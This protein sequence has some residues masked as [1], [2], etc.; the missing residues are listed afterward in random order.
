MKNIK[1]TDNTSLS[2]QR[3]GKDLLK[4]L[5]IASQTPISENLQGIAVI[6][7]DISSSMAGNKIEQAK[8]GAIDFAE[9]SKKMGL[10]FGLVTFGS[11][12]KKIISHE[13]NIERLKAIINKI[14]VSGSTNMS[15]AIEMSIELCQHEHGKK[16]FCIVTDGMPDDPQKTIELAR[17]AKSCGIHILTIGTDDA[18]NNFLSQLA[19]KKDY[20]TIIDSKNLRNSLSSVVKMLPGLDG[21]NTKI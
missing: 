1:S 4:N 3:K 9:G 8:L 5:E 15:D 16:T 20:N 17:R 19:T 7:L 11:F 13:N 12:A 10:K 14:E 6:L 21:L 2:F 18:D